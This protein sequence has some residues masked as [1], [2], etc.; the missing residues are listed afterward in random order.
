[1]SLADGSCP[2]HFGPTLAVHQAAAQ[3]PGFL[4]GLLSLCHNAL[5]LHKLSLADDLRQGVFYSDGIGLAPPVLPAL[6]LG[7][8]DVCPGV[9]LISEHFIYLS[10]FDGLAPLAGDAG[11]GQL[12]DDGGEALPVGGGD[13]YLPDI[14]R[15]QLIDHIL[16]VDH[17]ISEGSIDTIRLEI[18]LWPSL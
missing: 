12:L 9:L 3:I 13:K 2:M 6:L 8:I 11:G 16:L 15:F 10:I 18:N 14:A 7:G 4:S 5:H 17:I 1:M